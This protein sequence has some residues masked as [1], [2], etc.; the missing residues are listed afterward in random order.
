MIIGIVTWFT[1]SILAGMLAQQKGRSGLG[2]FLLS[3]VLS[4]LV[5]VLAAVVVLPNTARIEAR[6]IASRV[7]KK[8][9]Y[10][11]HVIR[12]EALVCRY[13]GRD[14]APVVTDWG[15]RAL[16]AAW[17]QK[18]AARAIGV[19]RGTLSTYI[20]AGRLS[21]N[22]DGTIDP[23]AVRRAGFIIRTDA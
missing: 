8:C 7:G 23:A 18:E 15:R 2:V 20:H 19:T 14:V 22:P 3:L 11:A 12:Q 6:Q 17:S 5:G 4:P 21:T 16:P 9:L 10:C 13:C 1:L